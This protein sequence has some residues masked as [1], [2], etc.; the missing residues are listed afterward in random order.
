M[1]E[2]AVQ[3]SSGAELVLF[4]TALDQ[5][6]NCVALVLKLQ[7]L[8]LKEGLES[9]IFA[10]SPL[11]RQQHAPSTPWTQS[12]LTYKCA[13]FKVCKTNKCTS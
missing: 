6:R 11:M 3:T 13:A 5:F 2:L 7:A 1:S 10:Q 12:E 9:A 4:C 8:P